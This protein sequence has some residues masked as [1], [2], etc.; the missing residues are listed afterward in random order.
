MVGAIIGSIMIIIGSFILWSMSG[1]Y[2]GVQDIDVNFGSDF[3][4]AW[5]IPV[6]GGLV[7]ILAPVAFAIQ[8]K[9]AASAAMVFGLLAMLI[10]IVL[11][12][13]VATNAGLDIIDV[14]YSSN[15][16]FTLIY[17]GGFMA[18][19][20]GISAMSGAASL[21]G[22]IGRNRPPRQHYPPQYQQGYGRY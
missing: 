12:I 4:Y 14:F 9:G 20:G 17:L 16:G 15:F 13:H 22:A 7:I 11:P 6:F 10:A 19:F 8:S 2:I 1:T 18:I 3:V 5:L 21:G